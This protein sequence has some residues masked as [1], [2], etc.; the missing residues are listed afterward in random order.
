MID[1]V[2][3]IFLTDG[4]AAVV[5]YA[6]DA[7]VLQSRSVLQVSLQLLAVQGIM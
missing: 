5:A 1:A 7:M 3:G 6:A 4:F 2:S